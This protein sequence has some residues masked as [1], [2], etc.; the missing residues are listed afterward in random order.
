MEEGRAGAPR[1]PRIVHGRQLL[2]IERDRLGQVLGRGPV[3]R[4]AG[5][6]DL[7]DMA[8]PFGREYRLARPLEVGQGG[9]GV[10]GGDAGKVGGG[11][12]VVLATARLRHSSYPRVGEGAAH[13]RH[14]ARARE[15]DVGHEL[16][17]AEEVPRVLVSKDARPD[18]PD[19]RRRVPHRLTAPPRR[20]REAT[21][22]AR[23]SNRVDFIPS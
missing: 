9:G 2:D 7:A 6:E 8:H 14:V 11:E 15:P 21:A 4:D 18:P 20:A 16:P 1:L 17:L 5:A 23:P 12:Y 13:E 10:D 3:V 22:P 19:R